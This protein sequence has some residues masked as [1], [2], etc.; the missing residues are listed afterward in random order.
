MCTGKK[1]WFVTAVILI[2][3]A[4]LCSGSAESY[5]SGGGHWKLV[6]TETLEAPQLKGNE[7]EAKNINNNSF[8]TAYYLYKNGKPQYTYSSDFSAS[9]YNTNMDVLYPGKKIRIYAYLTLGSCSTKLPI[10]ANGFVQISA[11]RLTNNGFAASGKQI[12]L[13]MLRLSPPGGHVGKT[14]YY[15][16]PKGKKGQYMAIYVTGFIK[17][18]STTKHIYQWVE[19]S[20][21]IARAWAGVWNSQWGALTFTGCL[22]TKKSD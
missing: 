2:F 6:N 12:N 13:I 5:A 4:F 18:K 17:R 9:F 7:M 3:I 16:V 1:L 22:T 10:R 15:E 21:S 14:V 11:Q 8:A 20:S 19:D